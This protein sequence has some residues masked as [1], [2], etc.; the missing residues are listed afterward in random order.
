MERIASCLIYEV[1]SEKHGTEK[2]SLAQFM[3][4][5]AFGLK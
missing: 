2:A 3:E 1:C 5:Y 4:K